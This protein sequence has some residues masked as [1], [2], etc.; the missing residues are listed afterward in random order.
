MVFRFGEGRLNLAPEAHNDEK[1]VSRFDNSIHCSSWLVLSKRPNTTEME[2]SRSEP[3]I[4][5]SRGARY[6]KHGKQSGPSPRG[7]RGAL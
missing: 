2:A 1:K 5:R 3:P 4:S 6:A 7:R